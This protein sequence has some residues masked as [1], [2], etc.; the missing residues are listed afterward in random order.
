VGGGGFL[1]VGLVGGF[2]SFFG[3]AGQLTGKNI[4]ENNYWN[5]DLTLD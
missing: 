1:G 5:I 2:W 4:S 3:G